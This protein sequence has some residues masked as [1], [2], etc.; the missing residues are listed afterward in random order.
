MMDGST[1]LT[2]AKVVMMGEMIGGGIWAL[3]P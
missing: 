2:V 3:L 1:L